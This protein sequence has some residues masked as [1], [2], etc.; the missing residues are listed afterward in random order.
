MI[1]IWGAWSVAKMEIRILH[2]LV[3]TLSS[4]APHEEGASF[5]THPHPLVIT[6]KTNTQI[7]LPSYNSNTPSMA[8]RIY[9]A[10][11]PTDAV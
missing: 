9:S 3:R 10:H 6:T 1:S 8:D 4:T 5:H 2:S 7:K 11:T